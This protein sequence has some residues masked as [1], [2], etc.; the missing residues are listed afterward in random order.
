MTNSTRRRIAILWPK[1]RARRIAAADPAETP[2][3]SDGLSALGSRG[4]DIT[5]EDPL[6]FPWN[7]L[8]NRH[9]VYCALDPLRALRLALFRRRYDAIVSVGSSSAFLT[10]RAL[11]ATLKP[12]PIVMID[13]AMSYDWPLRKR[14][15]DRILPKVSHV[16][17]YGRV[18]LDYLAREYGES[19]TGVFIPHRADTRFY[20]PAA[21]PQTPPPSKPYLLAIGDD[22][23][24]DFQALADAFERSRA[25]AN[26]DIRCVIHTRLPVTA[27]DPRVELSRAFLSHVALRDL[28]RYAT[29]VVLPLKDTIH[30][31]GINSLVEAMSMRR[32]VIVSRSAGLAD[33]SSDGVTALTV[34]PGDV[35]ALGTAIRRLHDDTALARRIGDAGR[36]WVVRECGHSAYAERVAAVLS[37]AI[38]RRGRTA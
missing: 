27:R 10:H 7:P 6:P 36:E 19:P 33:Y 37:A 35:E 12:T 38:S 14:L 31:G 15:Q 22:V 26:C 23:S 1:P 30:A 4:F 13:P 28:Y 9:E 24:R 29:A 16:I 18:Q 8:A 20:D 2:D 3:Q 25:L 11:A 5:I 34:P 17:V 21:P 32:P